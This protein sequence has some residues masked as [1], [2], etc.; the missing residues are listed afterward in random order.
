MV[1]LTMITGCLLTLTLRHVFSSSVLFWSFGGALSFAA[2]LEIA[3]EE[4]SVCVPAS[5]LACHDF[6]RDG[7]LVEEVGWVLVVWGALLAA[8]AVVVCAR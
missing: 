6:A 4:H 5:V 1:S 8:C 2:A 7:V 3:T